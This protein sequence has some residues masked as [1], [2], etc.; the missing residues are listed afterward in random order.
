MGEIAYRLLPIAYCLLPIAYSLSPIAYCLLP[1]A[2][3]LLLTFL[4]ERLILTCYSRQSYHD[5]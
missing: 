5:P 1:L 3:C 2:S 4:E